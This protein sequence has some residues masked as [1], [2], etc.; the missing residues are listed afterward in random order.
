MGLGQWRFFPRRMAALAEFLRLLF[1]H[2]HEPL[3]ILVVGK[4]GGGL[5]RCVEQEKQER[6]A[7][8]DKHCIVQNMLLFGGHAVPWEK[9][10]GNQ[11]GN[12]LLL[13]HFQTVKIND[14]HA[15]KHYQHLHQHRAQPLMPARQRH[16]PAMPAV[17]FGERL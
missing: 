8:R 16:N 1:A 10:S 5:G 13:C 7:P 14:F 12:S 4:R 3:V 2:S 15:Q 17:F 9:G 11:A 6:S